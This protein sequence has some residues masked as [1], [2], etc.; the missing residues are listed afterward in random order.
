MIYSN[1][2]ELVGHTPL[3]ELLRINPRLDAAAAPAAAT[4][5]VVRLLAKIESKNIGGSI[6]DRVALSMIEAAE[7]SGELTPDKTVIEATSGN[8]GVG[9]AMVCAVK[10]YKIMLLM[11]ESASEERK[12]IMRAYGAELRLTPGHMGT[13]G[14]IEEAYRLAREEPGK[15]VLLDQYNNPASIAAH[16]R[17]TAQEIWDDTDGRVTHVVAS[18]GTTGTVMGL[19][20]RLHELNPAI[21]VVAV[22]PYAGHKIQGLKNMQESYPPGIWDKQQPDEIVHVE[23]E[24]AFAMARR[25]AREEGLLVGMSSGAA[26]AAAVR[27]AAELDEGLVVFL[28]PDSGERYLSTSLF[29]TPERTGQRMFSL[30]SEAKEVLLP[31]PKGLSVFTPGPALDALSDA[32]AWRRILLADVVVRAQAARGNAA[33]AVVG[34]ADMDDRALEAARAAGMSREAFAALC[35]KTVRAM[36]RR[37]GVGDGVRFVLA[38]SATDRALTLT[39]KLLGRGLAYEKLRSVYFDVQRERDYGA[40]SRADTSGLKIGHTVDLAAYAKDNP[41]DFTLLKRASLADLKAGDVLDTEW[42][43]VRPSWFL[44]LA[45]AALENLPSVDLFLAAEAHRFPHLENFAAIL[46]RAGGARPQ[47]WAVSQPVQGR[48]EGAEG[49]GGEE[50]ADLAG[51]LES[52]A[53]HDVRMWLLSTSYRKSLAV[54]RGSLAMWQRNRRKAQDLLLALHQAAAQNA[55]TPPDAEGAKEIEQAVHDLKGA[56]SLALE[57]DLGLHHFWP[58]LFAFIRRVNSR[59]AGGASG[60]AAGEALAALREV[61]AVLGFLDPVDAASLPLAPEAWP[62]KAAALVAERDAA[63]AARDFARADELRDRLAGMGLRVEDTP[64]GARVYRMSS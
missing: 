14:A 64:G 50:T 41:L 52:A 55:P 30:A 35:L 27:L 34:L 54:T 4:A 47:V 16:Y 43:K 12:R 28:C 1:L 24:A 15:Y 56:F 51:L 7:A 20:R 63:R 3:L 37:L 40:T 57:D 11:P 33:Q 6:K 2:L 62:A 17:G 44:Q 26:A 38:T 49:E 5:P 60:P 46:T 29:A 36:A 23:D 53:P 39:R 25:L 45:A 9:L 59:L 58:A 19:C 48:P 32:E 18:L 13:D 10:G 31:G 8:T 22:E 42:G 61:D 21:R